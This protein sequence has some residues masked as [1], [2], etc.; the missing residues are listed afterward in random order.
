MASDM[1][2]P[3]QLQLVFEFKPPTTDWSKYIATSYNT[4]IS[5]LLLAKCGVGHT[6]LPPC[7]HVFLMY[8]G[9]SSN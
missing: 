3:P 8:H 7:D 9:I 5:D 6:L 4:L 1:N 2:S